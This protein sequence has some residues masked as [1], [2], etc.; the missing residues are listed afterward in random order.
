MEPEE[1]MPKGPDRYFQPGCACS[2]SFVRQ[3][4]PPAEAIHMRQFVGTQLGEMAM[5]T[6]RPPAS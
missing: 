1:L 3:M 2:A 6:V 5:A 4:P